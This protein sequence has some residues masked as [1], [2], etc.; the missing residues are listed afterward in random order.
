M[1]D[2]PINI[3][4]D[5]GKLLDPEVMIL[6]AETDDDIGCIL[7]LHLQIEQ[8]LDFYLGVTRKG[9]IAEFVRQPR[10]F[11][12]KLSI[13]VALG[14]PIVFARVAKQVNAIRNRLAHEHKADISADA[15]KLLGK[16]VNEMQTLIPELIPVERHYI[17]LPRKRPN[18]KYSYGRGEVRL[19]FVLA[20]MAF[21]RAAVPWLVTQFA[22]QP[23]VGDSK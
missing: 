14:L 13:A 19:D 2:K 8:L 9:E 16:A 21:L 18:E 6:A 23:I 10:D 20:V 1:N 5:L 7:R 11:S 22:P 15:V 3:G 4:F 12:G 17:E